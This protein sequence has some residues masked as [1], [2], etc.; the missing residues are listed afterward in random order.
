MDELRLLAYRKEDKPWD[1]I[2]K[3]FPGRTET[4]VR[5]C[6]SVSRKRGE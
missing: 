1:W 2:L 3:K 4:V 6:V 5:Q